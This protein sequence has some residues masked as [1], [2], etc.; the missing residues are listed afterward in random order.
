M[1]DGRELNVALRACVC[2]C[3]HICM[4]VCVL[5]CGQGLC[6]ALGSQMKDISH[7]AGLVRLLS[8]HTAANQKA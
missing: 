2:V 5:C 1:S 3:T 8:Q 4:F 6:G 7:V